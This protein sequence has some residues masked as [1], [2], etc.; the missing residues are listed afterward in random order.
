MPSKR[1]Y[2][3]L[4]NDQM[5][6]FDSGHALW[7][8][9]PVSDSGLIR[10]G[11]V[12]Y[13]REGCFHWLFYAGLPLGERRRGVDA[14]RNFEQLTVGKIVK[15]VAP[16]GAGPL[17]TSGVRT[18][19]DPL[20]FSQP[21]PLTPSTSTSP[22]ASSLTLGP[23]STILFQLTGGQ[24][25][26]L[27]T[28]FS[29]YRE[30]VQRVGT[31]EKYTKEHYASWV[32]FARETGHGD[33]NPVLVTG[34]DR[35]RDFAM[36]CYSNGDDDLKCQ[37]T[38][39]ASGAG[40]DWGT[41]H[42]TGLV[43]TNHGPRS[44]TPPSSSIYRTEPVSDADEYNQCVFIRYY[45]MRKRL[46]VPRVIKAGAGP[47]NLGGGKRQGDGSSPEMPHDPDIDSDSDTSSSVCDSGVDGGCSVTSIETESDI[48]VHNVAAEGKDD[49]DVVAD[50]IFQNSDADSVLLHHQDISVLRKHAGSVD[51]SSLLL[52]TQPPIT[53]DENGVGT[54][55][56]QVDL[57]VETRSSCIPTPGAFSTTTSDLDPRSLESPSGVSLR[58]RRGQLLG[59]MT[60]YSAYEEDM[61]GRGDEH[62]GQLPPH[63]VGPEEDQVATLV[64]AEPSPVTTGIQH[65]G[66]RKR[67][68]TSDERGGE[69]KRRRQPKKPRNPE[70]QKYIPDPAA[71]PPNRPGI[72]PLIQTEYQCDIE[73]KGRKRRPPIAFTT[74]GGL[75]GINLDD[76]LNMHF[77]YLDGRDDPMFED[78]STGNSISLRI[79]LVGHHL[80]ENVRAR[81]IATRDHRRVHNPI[82]RQK[83]GREIAKLIDDHLKKGG[84]PFHVPFEDLYLV[85]LHNVSP[86][87]WQ[88]ELWHKNP[89]A[90]ST[91]SYDISRSWSDISKLDQGG[92]SQ[93]ETPNPDWN[94]YS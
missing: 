83:L 32:A 26:A 48:V 6:E 18:T 68:S 9:A 24:G 72:L 74:H 29:I 82:T 71:P 79:E 69:G 76:A 25:A 8:P 60:S 42:K 58:S 35:T 84:S 43:Y 77:P 44:R 81:Q 52:E 86:A 46:G 38:T 64:L 51:L 61:P 33:V 39:S 80:A 66:K 20:P 75:Q 17:C 65:P 3:K 67:E 28:K 21:P 12:G 34:V 27:L 78:G 70:E 94:I 37:F 4:Y 50:Y 85:R 16:L 7:V 40:P 47:H 57:Q 13:V 31:F 2:W 19:S 1:P 56:P 11:D 15:H 54:V 92:S 89:Q 93:M 49:F 36:F 53:V 55:K 62:V 59:L 14:P 90:A 41:W 88:P 10:P 91:S 30:E 22:P 63:P 73:Q 87:S 5:S 45:T 23:A